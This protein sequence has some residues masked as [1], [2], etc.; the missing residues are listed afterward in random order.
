MKQLNHSLFK[1]TNDQGELFLLP[2]GQDKKLRYSH[3]SPGMYFKKSD[4]RTWKRMK[5]SEIDIYGTVWYNCFT[6][7]PF[8]SIPDDFFEGGII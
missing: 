2:I 8:D 1:T 5:I 7:H 3:E 6:E 4:I